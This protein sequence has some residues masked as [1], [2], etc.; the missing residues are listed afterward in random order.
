VW[1]YFQNILLDCAPGT[2]ER[3]EIIPQ[4]TFL[5]MYT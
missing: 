1:E 4:P 5:G 3:A 2:R